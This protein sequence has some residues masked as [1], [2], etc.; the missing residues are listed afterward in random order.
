MDLNSFTDSSPGE[1]VTIRG[2]TPQHGDWEHRAFLPDALSGE[3]PELSPRT[4]ITVSNA[5]AALAALDNTARQLPNPQLLRQPTLRW[6]A[7]STSALEGT[8]ASL[9]EVITADEED[10]NSAEMREIMNYVVMANSGYR[11]HT[12]GRHLSSSLLSELQGSLMRGT[13]LQE[14]SG[15]LR[16]TQ[17][18]IG[19]REGFLPSDLPVQAARFVPIP[20]GDQLAAGVDHLMEWK[21]RDHSESIDPV[22]KAGMGQY[23]FETL[24]PFRDGNGRLGRYLITLDL[25]SSGILSEPTLTVSPWFEARRTEYY[26]RLLSVSTTGAWDAFIDFF[27]H[28]LQQ[29]ATST[30]Q[31]MLKLTG[32]QAQLK[33]AIR[34]SAIRADSAFSLVDIATAHPTFTVKQASADLGLSDA[35]TRRVI[36]QL[37]DLRILAVLDP[38]ASYRRRYFSPQILDVLLGH[39]A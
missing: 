33:E 28:G 36:D 18:V 7:Q 21:T 20:A 25:L 23:Q 14:E 11:W 8:Y 2:S 22:V 32:V 1:L 26:E 35:G 4:F 15:R 3:M 9:P 19:R 38:K 39:S 27:A 31:Q 12:A 37:V 5:R 24:H 6:E 30:Q 10:V 17:V 16:E 34:N 29:A 13:P